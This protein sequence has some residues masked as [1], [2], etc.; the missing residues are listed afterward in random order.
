MGNGFNIIIRKLIAKVLN[1]IYYRDDSCIICGR[2]ESEF[3]CKGCKTKILKVEKPFNLEKEGLSLEIYSY[4]YYGKILR[5]L[6]IKLKYKGD[7][8][9]ASIFASFL[10]EKIEENNFKID[11][12][13]YIPIREESFKKRGF[14]QCYLIAK[15]LSKLTSIKVENLLEVVLKGKDQIGL[16]PVDRFKNMEGMFKAI[17]KENIKG[18]NI[19]LIDDVLTTGATLFQ[20]VKELKKY[21]GEKIII[22]TVAKSKL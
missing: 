18:K 6:M 2:E 7:Y 12:I 5:E 20:G 13:T 22:L 19:L 4:G 3:L 9:I 11:Y 15:E 16:S 17:E 10:F 1:T 14:N 21:Y 8:Q